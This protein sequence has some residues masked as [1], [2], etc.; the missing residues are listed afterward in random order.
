MKMKK[1]LEKNQNYFLKKFL[2]HCKY[3]EQ[4]PWTHP[5]VVNMS[6]CSFWKMSQKWCECMSEWKCEWHY[7]YFFLHFLS[8]NL[9]VHISVETNRHIDNQGMCS[10]QLFAIL[11]MFLL[12]LLYWVKNFVKTLAAK[13]P[14][15]LRP[16]LTEDKQS[17]TS[18][19]LMMP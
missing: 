18:S 1:P 13:S 11:A 8:Q 3:Q 9:L 12:S 16:C 10:G 17:C 4:I 15:Y 7:Y 14:L 19:L 5:S 2:Q 6:I